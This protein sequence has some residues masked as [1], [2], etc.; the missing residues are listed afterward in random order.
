MNALKKLKCY[1]IIKQF[2]ENTKAITCLDESTKIKS[3]TASQTRA[4]LHLYCN[5]KH[6][7][8]LTGTPT[9]NSPLDLYA[10][11]EFLNPGFWG[12]P[13]FIFE[14]HY[15][16]K[17]KM[18]DQNTNRII[19]IPISEKYWD[20]IKDSWTKFVSKKV[21]AVKEEDYDYFADKNNVSVKDLKIIINSKNYQPYKNMGELKEKMKSVTFFLRKED[22]GL[23]LPSKIYTRITAELSGEQ[24][25]LLK[26][27]KENWI[28][29]YSGKQ[30]TI[31]NTISLISRIQI[32]RSGFFP[33]ENFE[34]DID[35][36]EKKHF[37]VDPLKENPALTALLD[38]IELYTFDSP[39]II[40]A[41]YTCE[42]NS[43]Y[44][45]LLKVKYGAALM[46]GQTP[47][48]E[49]IR[50]E[51]DFKAFIKSASFLIRFNPVP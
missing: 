51:S 6:K 43:I 21:L 15:T 50:I 7:A 26:E 44:Q 25:R 35:G 27:L 12:M 23:D 2:F 37:E 40:W 29:E 24:K 28:T 14:K 31:S 17:I 38:D 22:A 16:I 39:V 41:N 47:D 48:S 42:L 20:I 3:G 32:I 8:I 34:V 49:R 18:R 1:P 5:Q 4:I 11:F 30:L 45:A 10:Q 19:N 33:Y 9:P 46:N 36:N 13:Y